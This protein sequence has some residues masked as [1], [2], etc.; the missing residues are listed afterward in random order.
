MLLAAYTEARNTN[1]NNS[2]AIGRLTQEIIDSTAKLTRLPS[3]ALDDW[4]FCL[5]ACHFAC[6]G[7]FTDAIENYLHCL[8]IKP[9][10]IVAL[11]T[12]AFAADKLCDKALQQRLLSAIGTID[13]SFISTSC[14]INDSLLKAYPYN[15]PFMA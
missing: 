8:R 11:H 7:E 6:L 1:D 13:P 5:I 12:G 9:Y 15:V 4:K 3:S 14:F 2:N 10:N